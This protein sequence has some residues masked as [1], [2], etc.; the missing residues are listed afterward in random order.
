VFVLL[1]H[2]GIV[3]QLTQLLPILKYWNVPVWVFV[4]VATENAY[5]FLGLLEKLAKEVSFYHQY[6]FALTLV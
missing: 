4:I 2:H 5:V 3:Y 6:G 1:V